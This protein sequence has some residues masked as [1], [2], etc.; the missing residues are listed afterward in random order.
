MCFAFD[1]SPP[2]LPADLLAPIAGGAGAELLELESADGTRFSAALAESPEP[3]GRGGRDPPGRPRPLPVLLRARRAL[4]RTPA[5]TRSR[6]TTSA[7]PPGSGRAA[8]T[9][10]T[11]RTSARSD[12]SELVQADARRARWRRCASGPAPTRGRV[13]RVLLRRHRSR[14]SRPR[15]PTSASPARSA[16]TAPSTRSAGATTSPIH[17]AREM[18]CPVLGL[19]GGADQGIPPE[20]VDAFAANLD[21]RGRR[22]RD[23]H[24][25]GRAALVLRPPLRGARRR[26]RRRLA[27]SARVPLAANPQPGVRPL[28]EG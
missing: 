26:V 18:R 2:D 16:S 5:T 1:A 19:F 4:R 28:V 10:S 24:L 11:C 25:P 27:A 12:R 8:R 20:Q 13:R 3:R 6:S 14:S 9:S 21:E 15:A 22:A 23:R 17:R 7:A